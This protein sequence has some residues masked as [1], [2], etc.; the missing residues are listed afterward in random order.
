MS[1]FTC[2]T[3]TLSTR[4]LATGTA[5]VFVTT[6]NRQTGKGI[7]GPQVLTETSQ[8][9][10]TPERGS[11]QKDG[12][13]PTADAT[14]GSE[15]E[16]CEKETSEGLEKEKELEAKAGEMRRELK[17]MK[18]EERKFKAKLRKAER[19]A[20]ETREAIRLASLDD[21]QAQLCFQALLP[22]L[23]D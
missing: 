6:D 8:V 7:M 5:M 3:L 17:Q 19:V 22:L 16:S 23:D 12:E 4:F 11:E 9:T 21:A 13:N 20:S 15:I 2:L 10:T 18:R 1:M 14:Q